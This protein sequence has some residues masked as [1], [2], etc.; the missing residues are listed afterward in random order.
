MWH[1]HRCLHSLQSQPPN[2]CWHQLYIGEHTKAKEV[3][4]WKNDRYQ[5]WWPDLGSRVLNTGLCCEVQACKGISK[6]KM[7]EAGL[8]RSMLHFLLNGIRVTP[9]KLR[10][11]YD[12]L[13]MN[14]TYH[15]RGGNPNRCSIA[16][17]EDV[18]NVKYLRRYTQYPVHPV[19]GVTGKN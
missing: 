7:D 10:I 18:R 11:I 19:T 14:E 12:N 13:I 17:R 8:E 3:V 4:T 2:D 6:S 5:G 1:S 16:L 15:F 9:K